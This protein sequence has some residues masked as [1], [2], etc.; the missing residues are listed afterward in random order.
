MYAITWR[1]SSTIILFIHLRIPH[2]CI[3]FL[4]K[5]EMAFLND[6]TLIFQYFHNLFDVKGGGGGGRGNEFSLTI[7]ERKETKLSSDLFHI[8]TH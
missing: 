1:I 5:W 7:P 2:S 3:E 4:C 6:H 8:L